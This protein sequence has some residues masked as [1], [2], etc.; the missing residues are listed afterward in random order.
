MTER[1]E[2]SGSLKVQG[3]VEAGATVS[4]SLMV[5]GA[6][7]GEFVVESGGNLVLQG[8]AAGDYTIRHGGVIA[9]QGAAAGSFWVEDGGTLGI[10]GVWSGQVRQWDGRVLV[11]A[12]TVFAQGESGE[13]LQ[14]DGSF[15]AHPHGGN[16]SIN[17]GNETWLEWDEDDTFYPARRRED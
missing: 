6:S 11:S 3:S 10:S 7:A 8:A 12:G 9:V 16:V 4:G 5:Q 15:V 17:V 13:V 1:L 14:A 2:V